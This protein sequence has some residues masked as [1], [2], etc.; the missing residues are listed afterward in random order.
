MSGKTN[1]RRGKAFEIRV[2]DA[3]IDLLPKTWEITR[4]ERHNYGQSLHDITV[5][6]GEYEWKIDCK[7]T[8]SHFTVTTKLSLL[9]EA[10]KKYENCLLIVGQCYGKTKVMLPNVVVIVKNG[11]SYT[12]FPLTNIVNYF[13]DTNPEALQ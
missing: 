2:R 8:I 12:E 13:S 10:I 11:E 1:Q 4:H 5:F 7:H 6:D 9:R 3:L